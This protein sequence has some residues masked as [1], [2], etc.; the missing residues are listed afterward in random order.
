MVANDQLHLCY[1]GHYTPYNERR[2]LPE[3]DFDNLSSADL[4]SRVRKAIV[5]VVKGR[6]VT[7]LS[8]AIGR[9]LAR[10]SFFRT[11]AFFGLV[12]D[13]ML[14]QLGAP[15]RALDL[16]CGA[17]WLIEKLALVGWSVEGL[18][19]NESA[20]AK[21]RAVTGAVVHAGDF[22]ELELPVAHY[23]LIVLNHVIEHFRDPVVVL[24]R[25]RELLAPDGIV[26]LLYP[27]PNSFGAGWF[28]TDWFA[29]DAPRHLVLPTP[30]A[31][32]L[33]AKGA[34]FSSAKVSTR[35]DFVGE[36]WTRSK[37]FK[38]SLDPERARPAL[39]VIEQLG[40]FI[41]RCITA[42]G[43]EKGWEVVATLRK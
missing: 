29:W 28:K 39:S 13:V 43:F 4:R 30:D 10:H 38:N 11:R 12:D 42:V 25:V 24:K 40:L 2:E 36:Q 26:V 35:N 7:G 23:D 3:V 37:A 34:G 18:E 17:G 6:P 14:P 19:W 22:R 21:A 8:G 16:G 32:R 15:R 27:N 9:I 20:A 41:D 33:M 1:P 5:D 31:V